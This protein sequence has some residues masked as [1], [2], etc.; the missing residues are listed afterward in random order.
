M[1]ILYGIAGEGM[2]HATRSKAIIKE[3]KKKNKII[4][5]TGGRSYNYLK[6]LSKTYKIHTLHIEYQN[7]SVSNVL[8]TIRQIICSPLYLFSLIKTAKIILHEKPDM[9][10]ND[11][12][13]FTCYIGKLF[14][15]PVIEV[16][17]NQIISK[18]KIIVPK[19]NLFDY[20]KSRFI[21]KSVVP[22]AN[23][24]IIASFFDVPL[25]SKKAVIVY[26]PLRKEVKRIRPKKEN[27]VLVYQTS[28]T[29]S[30]L[31]H[32]LKQIGQKF[33]V[34]GFDIA[35]KED[36]LLFKKFNEKE[37]F[38][39]LGNCK[40]VITNGGFTLIS[41][42]IYL[43]KPVL[44]IPVKKQFEQTTNAIYVDRLG[45]GKMIENANKQSVENFLSNLKK[46]ENNLK[47]YKKT[48]KDAIS[49]IKKIIKSLQR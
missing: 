17:N 19:N 37:F 8:T 24:Y 3:L 34:Y 10:V 2:G 45:F 26:P 36:N 28:K 40:A 27:Y 42:A 12:D 41:E 9:I 14:G 29:N 22:T 44:S 47:K 6:N 18:G 4:I 30:R 32:E 31:L 48:K 13:P 16:N 46:Y 39:D 38:S 5:V 35:K 21:L 1:R 33:V 20:L 49:E 25:K 43:K 23:K 15:I 7:N 11:F